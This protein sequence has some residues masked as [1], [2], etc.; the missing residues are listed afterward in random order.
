MATPSSESFRELILCSSFLPGGYVATWYAQVA[1]CK[2][3]T[4]AVSSL[5][6]SP[7]PPGFQVKHNPEWKPPINT[8]GAFTPAA[9]T[10]GTGST[11]R[12]L[13]VSSLERCLGI[14]K[15]H[16]RY[17]YLVPVVFFSIP[18]TRYHFRPSFLSPSSS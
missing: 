1:G 3:R 8:Y 18:Y 16:T 17:R 11:S 10:A 7:P 13:Q 4:P 5:L 14:T 15:N 2:E 6:S 12:E 9:T